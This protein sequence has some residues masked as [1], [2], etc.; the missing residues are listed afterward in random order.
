MI[1]VKIERWPDQVDPDDPHEKQTPYTDIARAVIRNDHSGTHE[2]GSY[3]VE[4]YDPPAYNPWA[5]VVL[6]TEVHDFPRR[7]LGAWDLVYRALDSLV[8]ERNA[9]QQGAAA[10]EL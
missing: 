6:E 3:H 8:R 9:Q 4:L 1:I 2:T 5:G 7:E 10:V